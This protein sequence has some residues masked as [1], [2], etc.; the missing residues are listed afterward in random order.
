MPILQ[1]GEE[2]WTKDVLNL[3]VSPSKLIELATKRFKE[4]G[5]VVMD[6]A[7]ASGAT[8]HPNGV[9]LNL[10]DSQDSSNGT[11]Q[12]GLVSSKL[13]LDCMGHASPIVRQNRCARICSIS[14]L[15]TYCTCALSEC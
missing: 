1:G 9:A 5:G 6:C 2:V 12:P 11:E 7:T 15:C 13:L 14:H 3:G 10:S 4:N 8:V